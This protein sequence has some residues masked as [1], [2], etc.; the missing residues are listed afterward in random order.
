LLCVDRKAIG[1]IEAKKVGRLLSGVAEQSAE[2]AESLPDFMEAVV[3]GR[4]HKPLAPSLSDAQL[5]IDALGAREQALFSLRS[6]DVLILGIL[7]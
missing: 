5:C 7:R 6:I 2:Y 1:I 3:S 4:R